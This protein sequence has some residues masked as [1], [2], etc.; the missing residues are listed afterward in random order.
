MNILRERGVAF[1]GSR[2]DFRFSICVTWREDSPE[3]VKK[4]GR[5]KDATGQVEYLQETGTHARTALVP[6][7]YKISLLS[8]R[9][10]PPGYIPGR[11]FL[12]SRDPLLPALLVLSNAQD[13]AAG[14]YAIHTRLSF[15]IHKF[16]SSLPFFIENYAFFPWE[17]TGPS[18]NGKDSA[19]SGE[20]EEGVQ[21]FWGDFCRFW[22]YPSSPLCVTANDA[23]KMVC[24][25][26]QVRDVFD[27]RRRTSDSR[28]KLL[29]IGSDLFLC[30]VH[31]CKITHKRPENR[32]RRKGR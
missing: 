29:P 32:R 6:I 18:A 4:K 5:K 2:P 31:A 15:F 1:R 7:P 21:D 22:F 23:L 25:M 14:T 30:N 9:S 28:M 8:A 3:I 27:N 12:R 13:V 11:S 24:I 20:I 10:T 16:A 17:S 26:Y 19:G